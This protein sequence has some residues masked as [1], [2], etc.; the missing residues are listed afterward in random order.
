M[1]FSS[2]GVYKMWDPW[3]LPKRFWILLELNL[4]DMIVDIVA[5]KLP[6]PHRG[7]STAEGK[8]CTE[9][10]AGIAFDWV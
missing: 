4:R 3:S 8:R 10:I 7:K 6:F 2:T 1:Y 9:G 5:Q